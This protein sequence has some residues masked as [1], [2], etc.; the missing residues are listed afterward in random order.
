MRLSREVD[1]NVNT[2]LEQGINCLSVGNIRLGERIVR[3]FSIDFKFSR[4][5]AYVSE[6]TLM[7]L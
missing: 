6:S 3:V 4:F 7:I 1:Y 2:L 5:P